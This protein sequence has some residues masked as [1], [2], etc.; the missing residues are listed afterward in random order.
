[1]HRVFWLVYISLQ[2]S[3][4][5][6]PSLQGPVQ[7]FKALCTGE[8]GVSET[9]GVTLFYTN[10]LIHRVVLGGWIEGG[11]IVNGSVDTHYHYTDECYAVQHNTRGIVGMANSGHNTNSSQFYITLKAT[12]W[13]DT[14]YVTFG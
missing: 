11:D 2:L 6:C 9:T 8:K 5:S 10:T 4:T 1:M 14:V 7:N 13:M 12:P 3:I